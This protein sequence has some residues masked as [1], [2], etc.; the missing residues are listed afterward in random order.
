MEYGVKVYS[1]NWLTKHNLSA[2][3]AARWLAEYG[4]SFVVAQNQYVPMADNAIASEQSTKRRQVS[5][6]DDL[7]FIKELH[8]NGLKYWAACNVFFDPVLMEH[9]HDAVPIDRRGNKATKIDW[10]IGVCPTHE[11]YLQKKID[12]VA[13]AVMNLN[14]DGIHLGFTRFPGFWELWLPDTQREDHAEYCFC[15]RCCRKFAAQASL[16]IPADYRDHPWDWAQLD[17]IYEQFAAWK[18]D[19]IRQVIERIR[20][21]IQQISPDIPI[22][23]NTVPFRQEDFDHAG[24]EVFGQD[25]R[26]LS[27]VTDIFEVMAYHQ[28]LGRNT[29]WIT[30]TIREIKTIAKRPIAATLQMHPLYIDG[31]H[32]GDSRSLSISADEFQE[33]IS[34]AR[35]GGADRIIFFTWDNLLA[36]DGD[37]ELSRKLEI[38][39]AETA[40]RPV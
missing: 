27:A 35:R 20:Q 18:S 6:D 38:I 28:V 36:T 32:V 14:P 23:L 34:A 25:W 4:I 24:Y 2:E 5:A 8:K 17:G 33:A 30:S 12:Q 19:L 39:K 11:E 26:K 1:Y 37:K 21:E 3:E 29:A 16:S 31:I 22:M 9:F 10:Y 7:R 15:K 13:Q 40:R